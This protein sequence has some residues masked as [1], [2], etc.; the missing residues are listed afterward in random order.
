MS[1]LGGR[2]RLR[3]SGNKVTDTVEPALTLALSL[4]FQTEVETGL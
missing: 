1:R 2:N 3:L 4:R